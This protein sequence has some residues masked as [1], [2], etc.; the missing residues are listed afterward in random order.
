ML[1][2]CR[3]LLG[4]KSFII[5]LSSEAQGE[6][7]KGVGL[8]SNQYLR[9]QTHC[10]EFLR[11]NKKCIARRHAPVGIHFFSVILSTVSSKSAVGLDSGLLPIV[12]THSNKA[13]PTPLVPLPRRGLVVFSPIQDRLR[14][15]CFSRRESFQLQYLKIV[16][17]E[18]YYSLP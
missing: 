7:L 8:L 1:L 13:R 12:N 14:A 6:G 11:H 3:M 15:G 4:C 9:L 2:A 17:R 16:I 10:I 5:A 18:V